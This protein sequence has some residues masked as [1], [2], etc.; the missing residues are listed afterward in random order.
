M[1]QCP[2]E[3]VENKNLKPDVDAEAKKELLQPSSAYENSAAKAEDNKSSACLLLF[4]GAAGMIVMVLGIA[5]VLP[6]DLSGISKYMTYGIMS[7]LFLLFIVMGMIS[8]KS[9]RIFARKAESENSLRSTM[10]KWCRGH[11]EGGKLDEEL[12][13]GMNGESK[14]SAGS[15]CEAWENIAEEEKYFRRTSLV[16]EKIQK[17]FL[18]LDEGFLE[19][20]IDEIYEEIFEKQD[21]GTKR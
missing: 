18:N 8:M 1:P 7:A 19:H 3:K 16:K 9:Y 11:L 15:A 12:R 4:F 20:F 13:Q 6:F 17:Q 10:E 2:K 14:E 21:I 5:G